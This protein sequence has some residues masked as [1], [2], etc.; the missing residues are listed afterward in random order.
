MGE[1][2][3]LCGGIVSLLVEGV[4][5]GVGDGPFWIGVIVG[6][7]GRVMDGPWLNGMFE[8]AMLTFFRGTVKPAVLCIT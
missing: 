7:R 8:D 3:L 1:E 4:G 2:S 5:G 6:F